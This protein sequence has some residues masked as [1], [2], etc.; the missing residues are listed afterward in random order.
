MDRLPLALVFQILSRLDDSADVG[1]CRVAWKTFDT[2]FPDLRSI[3]LHWPLQ[4]YIDLRSRNSSSS[5]QL[6]SPLKTIFLNLISNLKV[7]ESVHIGAENL[8]L[9]VS[10]AD[11]E[12]YGDDMYLTDGAFV[13]EWLPRVS[14]TLKSLSISDFWI[15]SCWRRSEV[16]SLVSAYCHNLL[17]LELKH[18]WLSMANVNPMP[19]LTTLTLEFI[20]LDDKYL[21][22]LNKGF[23]NLQVLNLIG[24]KGLKLPMIHLLNLKTCHWT[25]TDTL[26]SL[27]LI[28]P[29]LITLKLECV[30][31]AAMYI[32]APLLSYFHF[33]IDNVRAISFKTFDNL[34]S[35]SLKSSHI[36]S[37][38]AKFPR[39]ETVENLTIESPDLA[40][41]AVENSNFTL[42]KLLTY[43]PTVTSLCFNSRAWSKFEASYESFEQF[44]LDGRKGV[45]KFRGYLLTVDPPL[46]FFLV[47]CVLEQCFNLVDVSLLFRRDV[48]VHASRRF[49]YW[50][51]AHWPSVNWRWGTWAEGTED[52]WITNGI[53]NAHEI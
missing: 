31:L 44:D 3:N 45:Q 27:T 50:C 34:K 17:E 51:T 23:P 1:R 41:G 48:D 53:P 13:N 37:L 18:A 36:C 12:D 10:N 47:T 30:R 9:D 35:L 40:M 16:L 19:N 25:V 32:E 14:G 22:E 8:P 11:V 24:V 2:L 4:R 49:I 43:F 26:P 15:Q 38:A 42:K 20:R 39:I 5:S 46:T 33:A 21:T 52:S 29:N 6:S 28:T 7:L